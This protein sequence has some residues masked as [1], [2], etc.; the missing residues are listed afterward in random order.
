MKTLRNEKGINQGQLSELMKFDQAQVS[1]VESGQKAPTA[2]FVVAFAAAV[3]ADVREA[4]LMAGYPVHGNSF[5]ELT[6][7]KTALEIVRL[8]AEFP[9]EERDDALADTRM[10][11]KARAERIKARKAKPGSGPNAARSKPAGRAKSD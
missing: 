2:D 9:D 11:L 7:E 6:D 10:L 3:E 4:L 1:R 8:L 5:K